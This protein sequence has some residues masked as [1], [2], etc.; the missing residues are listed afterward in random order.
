MTKHRYDGLLLG[1]H[2]ATLD[3]DASF[4]AIEDGAVAWKDGV[5]A[6]VGPRTGLPGA[7]GALAREVIETTGWVTPGLVDCHTHL[8]FAGNRAGVAGACPPFQGR[9]PMPS[10]CRRAVP[11]PRAASWR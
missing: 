1:A 11:M 5:L 8:V 7:P 2:L 4:G 10:I 6:Y 3:G 9:S